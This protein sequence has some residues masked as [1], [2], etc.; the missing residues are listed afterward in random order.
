MPSVSSPVTV[1][2]CAYGSLCSAWHPGGSRIELSSF[3]PLA[4]PHTTLQRARQCTG[5]CMCLMRTEMHLD[6][7]FPWE[8]SMD[9]KLGTGRPKFQPQGQ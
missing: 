2:F 9:Q 7:S 6:V 1:S 5:T 4:R 3:L 8:N